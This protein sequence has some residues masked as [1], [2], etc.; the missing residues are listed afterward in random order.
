MLKLI[1]PVSKMQ[2][3]STVPEECDSEPENVPPTI[4]S[5]PIKPRTTTVN[6]ST[7]PVNDLKIVA[8]F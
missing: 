5:T 6:Q 4:T 1:A 8:V 7:T 2:A 3:T